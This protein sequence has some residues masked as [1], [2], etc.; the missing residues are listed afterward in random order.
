MAKKKKQSADVRYAVNKKALKKAQAKAAEEQAQLEKRMASR[1]KSRRMSSAFLY[2]VVT[3]MVLFCLYTLLRTLFVRRAASLG[4]LRDNL[5]F[6]SLAAIPIVLGL[7]AILVHRLL[8]TRREKL[9]DRGRRLSNL[10]FILVLLAAFVLFGVQLRGGRAD[11]TAHPAC[12]ETRSALEQ[13]GLEVSAAEAPVL[14]QTLLEDSIQAELRCGETRVQIHYHA[15]RLPDI[16]ARFLEQAALDYADCSRT[17]TGAWTL[18]GPTEN[19]TAR[20]CAALLDGSAIRIVELRGPRA[21]V[22]ALLA[23]I[24]KD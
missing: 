14:V 10:L 15:G 16:A 24:V 4:A 5:L 23:L 21:E 3:L 8:K 7:G 22:E 20:A 18:W 2:G 13:S 6:V 1:E 11:A 17:E 12:A 9:S 19:E